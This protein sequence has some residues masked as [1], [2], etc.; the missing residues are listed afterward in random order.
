[1]QWFFRIKL[2]RLSGTTII[3]LGISIEVKK[4]AN[5]MQLRRIFQ[6]GDFIIVRDERSASLLGALEIPCSEIP[7]I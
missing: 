4:T 3:F 5:K 6:K 7:D 2:A 1:M